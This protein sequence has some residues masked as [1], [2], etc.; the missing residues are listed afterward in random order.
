MTGVETTEARLEAP[1]E[2]ILKPVDAWWTVLLTDPFA[3]RLAAALRRATAITP[4]H[5]TLAAHL[6]GVV[7]ALLILHESL[8]AAGLLFELRFV[9]DCADGKLA[10]L[11]GTSSA[12]GAVLDFVGD[13]LV[14]GAQ[15]V[16]MG[17][18]LTW[19]GEVPE[20]L[21]LGLPAAFL[22]HVAVGQTWKA[23]AIRSAVPLAP[24]PPT[25][26]YRRWMADHRL[27]PVPTRIDVEHLL[28]GL[29]PV[30]AG[31]TGEL[32]PIAVGVWGATAY[33][34]Y[35]TARIAGGA[36]RMAAGRDEAKG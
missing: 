5:L 22:A 23:E 27:R 15:L 3:V 1:S 24:T 36:Y 21:A 25:G 17:V 18:L 6:L 19:R 35:R 29:A 14:V 13:Y 28:L 26:G 12:A 10:R 11:R 33:F 7:G 31:A 2:P 4:T 30:V 20:P 16:A 34:G 32:G 8:L 9:L